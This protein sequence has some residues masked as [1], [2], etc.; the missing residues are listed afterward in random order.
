MKVQL[1]YNADTE[2]NEGQIPLNHDPVPKVM[3]KGNAAKPTPRK[4]GSM[5]IANNPITYGLVT[6]FFK[7]TSHPP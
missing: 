1:I 2:S 7:N 6:S 3:S 5:D 4:P